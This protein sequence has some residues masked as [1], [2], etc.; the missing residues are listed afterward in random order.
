MELLRCPVAH[1]ES[2]LVAS[3]TRQVERRILEGALGCPVCG[4]EYPITHGVADFKRSPAS[5]ADN[6]AIGPAPNEEAIVRLAAQLDLT[7]QG[8]VVLLAGNYAALAPALCVTFDPLLIVV[9]VTEASEQHLAE[10]ASV[11][12]I[13]TTVPLARS[14]LHGAAIDARNISRLGLEQ[15]SSLLRPRGRLVAPTASALPSDV[16]EL[17][18]DEFEWVATR[19]A[20]SGVIGLKRASR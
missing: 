11:M 18:R 4:A 3:T 16:R 14:A 13:A 5:E 9:G 17:A 6:D 10:H 20:D 1:E 8:R 7:E 15:V 12:R 19:S 2:A